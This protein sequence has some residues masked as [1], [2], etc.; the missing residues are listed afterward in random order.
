MRAE[1][2][3]GLVVLPLAVEC[4]RET[5]NERCAGALGQVS[6]GRCIAGLW[7]IPQDWTAQPPIEGWLTTA[8]LGAADRRAENAEVETAFFGN[9]IVRAYRGDPLVP[10]TTHQVAIFRVAGP[11]A[12]VR[13][14]EPG[15]PLED[16]TLD[17][18][19]YAFTR[20][21]ANNV[22]HVRAK[23]VQR[24][25]IFRLSRLLCW[26]DERIM[27]VDRN[28]AHSLRKHPSSPAEDL[29]GAPEKYHYEWVPN[30]LAQLSLLGP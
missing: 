15:A 25:I 13:A 7:E 10:R 29:V 14:K 9:V 12:R 28:G 23:Q 2:T 3:A 30:G 4:D 20:D 21:Y 8:L 16:A 1:S 19:A 5:I 24:S 18:K 17:T 27:V 26:P 11:P 6:P 22:W